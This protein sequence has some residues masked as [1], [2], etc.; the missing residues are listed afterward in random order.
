MN[1]DSKRPIMLLIDLLS[2]KWLMRIIWELREGSTTFRILQNK[3]GEISPTIVNKR[4][5]ELLAAKLICKTKPAGYRLT[6]L[7][8]ELMELFNPVNDWVKRWEQ[9][10]DLQAA[11]F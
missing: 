10:C 6:P 8:E 7:G 2:R 4:L 5:K 11:E 9:Q 3:C 1:I